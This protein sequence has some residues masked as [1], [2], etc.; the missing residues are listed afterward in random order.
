MSLRAI[1]ASAEAVGDGLTVTIPDGWLQGRT[2]FGGLSSALALHA[3]RRIVPDAPPLR[4]AQVAFVGPVSGNV[5]VTARLL[6]RGRNATWVTAEIA[7]QSGVGL[8]TTFVFMG[9]IDS[10]LQ[11]AGEAAPGGLLPPGEGLVPRNGPGFIG[12]FEWRYAAVEG[13]EPQA[14]LLRWVRL[15]DRE[16]LDVETELLCVADVLPPGVMPLLRGPEPISSMTWMCNLLAAAPRTDDGWWL[17]RSRGVYADAGTSSQ[18]MMLW[19]AAGEPVIAGM[20]SVA[21]FG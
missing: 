18:D 5:T 15:R 13:D 7:G 16:G 11:V 6:R 17:L 14:E 4:S 10:A 20:Q 3:A 9:A 8:V 2:A 21:V 19:N 1:L 12:N